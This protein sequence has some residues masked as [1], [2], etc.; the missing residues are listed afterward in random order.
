MAQSNVTFEN[1]SITQEIRDAYETLGM[2][3]QSFD[4]CVETLNLDA[5]LCD[6]I[7]ERY[8]TE[9]VLPENIQRAFAI[10]FRFSRVLARKSFAQ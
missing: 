10:L 6:Q 8:D 3:Q 1:I 2:T 9:D 5:D 4:L 7:M